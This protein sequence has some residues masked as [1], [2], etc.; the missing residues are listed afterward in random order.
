MGEIDGKDEVLGM[1]FWEQPVGFPGFEKVVKER[2]LSN[3]VK[4][5]AAS[6]GKCHFMLE[7]AVY[8]NRR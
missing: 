7:R 4:R 6:R 3:E 5:S 2:R 8:S 1:H